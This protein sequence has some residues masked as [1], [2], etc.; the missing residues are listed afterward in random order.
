MPLHYNK[1]E[2]RLSLETSKNDKVDIGTVNLTRDNGS[3]SQFYAKVIG[4]DNKALKLSD[5]RDR[6]Y[7]GEWNLVMYYDTI[8]SS[9]NKQLNESDIRVS[10]PYF[11]NGKTVEIYDAKSHS[12]SL[13]VDVSKFAEGSIYSGSGRGIQSENYTDEKKEGGKTFPYS[14]AIL[15]AALLG[16]IIFA[17]FLYIKLS[18]NKF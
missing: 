3:G 11:T 13:S 1:A 18:S 12:L 14:W 17:Y 16:V 15:I 7:L 4:S 9:G 5:E 10:V 6:F 8:N 2:H